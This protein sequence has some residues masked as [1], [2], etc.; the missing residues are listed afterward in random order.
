MR[1]KIGPFNA[2]VMV[3]ELREVVTEAYKF[4]VSQSVI[5]SSSITLGVDEL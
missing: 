2:S 1:E 5:Y 3:G 4:T